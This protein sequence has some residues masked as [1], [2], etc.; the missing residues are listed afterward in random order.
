MS[1][2]R[3]CATHGARDQQCTERKVHGVW[4]CTP[5]AALPRG[6]GVVT[7]LEG[8]GRAVDMRA[9]GGVDVRARAGGGE[10]RLAGDAGGEPYYGSEGWDERRSPVSVKRGGEGGEESSERI[11]SAPKSPSF[12]MRYPTDISASSVDACDTR[13]TRRAPTQQRATKQM[14]GVGVHC[15]CGRARHRWPPAAVG[16]CRRRLE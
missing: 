8:L 14:H 11:L 4:E 6:L 7:V 1:R 12:A 13:H 2:P 9:G 5:C 16:G 3:T 15:V 10:G